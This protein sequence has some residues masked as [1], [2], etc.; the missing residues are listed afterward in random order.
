VADEPLVLLPAVAVALPQRDGV[1]AGPRGQQ[2]TVRGERYGID[3]VRM[4]QQGDRLPGGRIP[5]LDREVRAG[6]RQQ[7]AIWRKRQSVDVG[8]VPGEGRQLLSRA[9]VPDLDFAGRLP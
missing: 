4:F 7:L 1:S 6:R 5:Q 2:V 3:P 9:D 8:L